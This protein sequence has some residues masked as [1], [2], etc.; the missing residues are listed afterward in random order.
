MTLIRTDIDKLLRP[1]P[2]LLDVLYIDN[3]INTSLQGPQI[4]STGEDRDIQAET[5]TVAVTDS[6]E[7]T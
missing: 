3:D 7:E 2:F 4:N 6:Q 1:L 5:P